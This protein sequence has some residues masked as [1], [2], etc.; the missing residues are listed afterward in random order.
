MTIQGLLAEADTGA[1]PID[2]IIGE[3]PGLHGTANLFKTQI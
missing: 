2:Q 3:N 1:G